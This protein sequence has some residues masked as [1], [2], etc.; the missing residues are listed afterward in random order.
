MMEVIDVYH[1]NNEI[2]ELLS[3]YSNDLIVPK[4]TRSYI[5]EKYQE[6]EKKKWI[7]NK[8]DFIMHQDLLG[9]LKKA[10]VDRG[11]DVY[12]PIE[13]TWVKFD[14]IVNNNNSRNKKEQPK[15][16]IAS[17]RIKLYEHMD[18]IALSRYYEGM[19]KIVQIHKKQRKK[20]KREKS[21]KKSERKKWLRKKRNRMQL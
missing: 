6:S 1:D 15:Y 17:F 9:K 8:Q 14:S 13:G 19:I 5:E 21:L 3:K 2:L 11:E 20:I 16:K 4:E 10:Y 7:M 18:E 12:N